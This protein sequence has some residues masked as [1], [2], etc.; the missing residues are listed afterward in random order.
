MRTQIKP[1]LLRLEG[2]IEVN[3]LQMSTMESE[4]VLWKILE[5]AIRLLAVEG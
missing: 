3:R 2:L 1:T 5:T 4:A